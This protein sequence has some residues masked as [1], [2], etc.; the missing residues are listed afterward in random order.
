MLRRRKADYKRFSEH[1]STL[2]NKPPRRAVTAAIGAMRT[3]RN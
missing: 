1:V 3:L 2:R